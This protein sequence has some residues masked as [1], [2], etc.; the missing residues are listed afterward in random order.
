[1]QQCIW[2]YCLPNNISNA[3]NKVDIDVYLSRQYQAMWATQL[4]IRQYVLKL[5]CAKNHLP[6]SAR[7]RKQCNY[8]PDNK[9][10]AIN[11]AVIYFER[12]YQATW[13]TQSLIREYALELFC[14]TTVYQAVSKQRKQHNYLLGNKCQTTNG[15][16]VYSVIIL[17]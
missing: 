5:L 3:T 4:S 16:V 2:H 9:H 17:S 8:L 12:Q 1:M 10:Q 11:N 6:N 13:T 15:I 7:Q 14:I